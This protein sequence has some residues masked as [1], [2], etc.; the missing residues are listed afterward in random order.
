MLALIRRWLMRHN[1]GD[2][3]ERIR[4][5]AKI[6][7]AQAKLQKLIADGEVRSVEEECTLKHF[8]A[9]SDPALGNLFMYARQIFLP[10]NSFVFGKIHKHPCLNFVMRGRV[11]VATEWGNQEIV[12]PCTFVSEPGA[13]RA[14]WVKE[15][16][17]WATV[18]LT[19]HSGEENLDK[20]ESEVVSPS[21]EDLGLLAR[22]EGEKQ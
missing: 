10:A 21:Y 13:K 22:F 19:R 6:L 11:V 4:E 7:R 5:R 12:A 17:I 8:F 18:H 14:L 16:T 2:T 15:D 3:P 1:P 9:P 20:I